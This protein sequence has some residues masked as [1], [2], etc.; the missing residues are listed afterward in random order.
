MIQPIKQRVNFQGGTY[1]GVHEVPE[2]YKNVAKNT[3]Q[4]QPIPTFDSEIQ[5]Q[6]DSKKKDKGFFR[7]I[8]FGFMNIA[9]GF[10]NVK[11][12]ASGAVR[13]AVEGLAL[14]SLVGTF[15]Y[16]YKNKKGEFFATLGGTVKNIADEGWKF[17]KNVPSIITK[18]TPLNTVTTVL[19]EPFKQFKKLKGNN[20]TIA[21]SV[22][23]A[24][25]VLSLRV[26]QGKINANKKNADIDH[27]LNEGHVLIK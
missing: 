26:I 22:I 9:K 13:G 23:T 11:D 21:A 7:N 18:R 8:K 4:T 17:I 5:I 14:G 25:S 16:N 1:Q 24:L 15:G 20:L 2:M 10:N 19:K 3:K 12:M 6:E 27:S